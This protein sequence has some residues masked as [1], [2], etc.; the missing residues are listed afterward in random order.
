MTSIYQKVLGEEFYK[1]H[2]K[3][4]ERFG[5][6]S[7]DKKVSIGR[8][9]M[10]KVWHGRAYT[11]PFLKWGTSKNILFPEAGK[12]VPFSIENY[13]YKD[14]LGRETVTFIRK[15]KFP[16]VLRRFDAT[17]IYSKQR[18]RIVDYLGTHQ[19][20]AVD[21]DFSVA[22][23]GGMQLESGEQRIYGHL[24]NFKCPELILGKAKV[25]EWFDESIDKFRISVSVVNVKWGKLF[26]YEGI[27]D[28]SYR[29]V[30]KEEDIPLDVKPLQEEIRE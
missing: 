4:Q 11:L 16:N 14:S 21:I 8:G 28:V 22:E 9:I 15:F 10:T 30:E 19:Q 18:K 13:A 7:Q 17:M 2:P 5:Y 23:N 25:C 1:L 3:I 27:F 12:D 26:G 20:M 29:Q 6:S 24:L